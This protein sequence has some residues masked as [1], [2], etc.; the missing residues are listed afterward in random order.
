MEK[1]W[2]EEGIQELAKNLRKPQGEFGRVVAEKMNEGNHYINMDTIGLLD[3]KAGQHVLEIGM[4]NGFFVPEVLKKAKDLRYTGLDYSEDMVAASLSNNQELVKS[5]RVKFIQ[6]DVINTPFDADSFDA[7][8]TINTIYFWENVDQTLAELYRV[9][10]PH[11]KLFISIRPKEAMKAYPVIKYGFN[12]F[13]GEVIEQAM[14]A[15]G[16]KETIVKKLQEPEQDIWGEKGIKHS[17]IVS[18]Q[19]I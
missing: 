4:G 18:G 1:Q 16:L 5:G 19:K 6:G 12:L 2:T 10:K 8:F 9:L 13:D 15:A 17:H 7:I 14:I 11:G 3:L